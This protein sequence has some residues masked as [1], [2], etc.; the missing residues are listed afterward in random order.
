MK[1]HEP[2]LKP[3]DNLHFSGCSAALWLYGRELHRPVQ[4]IPFLACQVAAAAH[5]TL[6]NF[7]I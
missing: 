4:S 5:E 2:V 6:D 7:I 3:F 1:V